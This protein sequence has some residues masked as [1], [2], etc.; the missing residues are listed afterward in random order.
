[1]GSVSDK[2]R[3]LADYI[4]NDLGPQEVVEMEREI[5]ENK[6]LSESLRLNTWVKNYLK[7]KVQLE[8]MRSD[9]QLEEAERLAEQVLSVDAADQ[10]PGDPGKLSLWDTRY[11]VRRFLFTAAASVALLIA[12]GLFRLTT[13]ADQLYQRYYEPF[14]ASD[15]TQRGILAEQYPEISRGIGYYMDGRYQES[16]RV[17]SVLEADHEIRAEIQFFTGISQMELGQFRQAEE[18]LARLTDSHSRYRPEALWYLSLCCLKN[19]EFERAS[20]LLDDLLSYEGMYKSD[21]QDLARKIRRI[22]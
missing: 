19:Q 18:N 22:K 5:K 6:E 7:A 10:K 9:P 14:E 13:D 1:M 11:R 8:D 12:I 16:I 21:A 15:H 2:N 3:H 20:A 4:F 17:F